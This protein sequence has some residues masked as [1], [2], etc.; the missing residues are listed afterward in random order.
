MGLL[1][2]AV[3]LVRG[4]SRI[5]RPA[6]WPARTL[7]HQSSVLSATPAFGHVRR[8]AP[9][10]LKKVRCCK[11]LLIPTAAAPHLHITRFR[12]PRLCRARLCRAPTSATP[13][14]LRRPANLRH[15][16]S[17]CAAHLRECRHQPTSVTPAIHPTLIAFDPTL[18]AAA[19]RR[20]ARR[21]RARRHRARRRPRRARRCRA[22][23]LRAHVLT[24]SVALYGIQLNFR[25]IFRDDRRSLMCSGCLGPLAPRTRVQRQ[26]QGVLQLARRGG[27]HI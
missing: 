18:L 12:C 7:I 13:A 27:A 23:R 21:H 19:R 2:P 17:R 14:F 5:A 20:R 15:C 4:T 1:V 8:Q 3:S 10:F 11:T 9:T 25:H 24:R 6:R 22:Y 16:T 26:R